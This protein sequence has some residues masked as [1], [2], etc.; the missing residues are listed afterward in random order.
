MN[1]TFVT[2]FRR[3]AVRLSQASADAS[4]HNMSTGKWFGTLTGVALLLA[5][6]AAGLQWAY[7]DSAIDRIFAKERRQGGQ[8]R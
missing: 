4:S 7:N 6:G 3:S 8:H 1:P 2:A 5:A